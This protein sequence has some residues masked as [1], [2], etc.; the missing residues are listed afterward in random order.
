[1]SPRGSASVGIKTG[2][3]V[4]DQFF[5]TM[6]SA[7]DATL[8][9]DPDIIEITLALVSETHNEFQAEFYLFYLCQT[10]QQVSSNMLEETAFR[11]D[12]LTELYADIQKKNIKILKTADNISLGRDGWEDQQKRFIYLLLATVKGHDPII[13]ELQDL[14]DFVNESVV[15]AGVSWDAVSSL[16]TDSPST[17]KARLGDI[18]KL[19]N[20]TCGL[21]KNKLLLHVVGPVVDMIGKLERS[22]CTLADVVL[23]LL[24]LAKHF[25]QMDLE[26]EEDPD[27]GW[28][29]LFVEYAV[30]CFKNRFHAIDSGLFFVALYLHPMRRGIASFLLR[31]AERWKLS[32][33]AST[34]LCDNVDEY[35]NFER[36]FAETSLNALK[37]WEELALPPSQYPP[38]SVA[39]RI[40]SMLPH[41]GLLK[42]EKG[43]GK[44]F[45]RR[46]GGRQDE[47]EMQT[48][49]GI[50]DYNELDIIG[51]LEEAVSA[52]EDLVTNLQ[53][54]LKKAKEEIAEVTRLGQEHL[55]RPSDRY[56]LIAYDAMLQNGTAAKTTRQVVVGTSKH[57]RFGALGCKQNSSSRSRE[58]SAA[59][60]PQRALLKE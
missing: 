41:A 16:F 10:L 39:I 2:P 13:L 46:K 29:N 49:E 4:V 25:D 60:R 33:K 59:T 20:V 11:T 52:D 1:M 35:H 50:E 56:D 32:S 53:Q 45:Q 36:K 26:Q 42:R 37:Y 22:D 30:S 23:E 31:L 17:M 12:L 14:S 8:D 7:G 27:I 28:E 19:E 18:R 3:N 24:C 51:G 21:R 55:P 9:L 34:L 38:I 48:V 40:F 54:E 57:L 47:L 5:I 58:V 15:R 44:E 43:E 6:H